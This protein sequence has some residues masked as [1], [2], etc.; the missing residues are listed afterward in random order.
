[1][2]Y[3]SALSGSTAQPFCKR[4]TLTL[5]SPGRPSKGGRQAPAPRGLVRKGLLIRRLQGGLPP[6]P[7]RMGLTHVEQRGFGINETGQIGR[8]EIPLGADAAEADMPALRAGFLLD[9]AT[10]AHLG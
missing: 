7:S 2:G 10:G 6:R 1:M 8:E 3:T 5:G 9:S 4:P